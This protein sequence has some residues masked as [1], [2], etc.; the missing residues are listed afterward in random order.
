M[1]AA[2]PDR[3]DL[4]VSVSSEA[5]ERNGAHVAAPWQEFRSRWRYRLD[6]AAL[7][8]GCSEDKHMSSDIGIELTYVIRNQ[9]RIS[10]GSI[11]GF[12]IHVSIAAFPISLLHHRFPTACD[13]IA[14]CEVPVLKG[15]RM[16]TVITTAGTIYINVTQTHIIT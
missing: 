11:F 14:F 8:V 13:G 7:S 15:E 16:R 2:E 1:V 5:A 3:G 6:A 10:A 9:R 4:N 12:P